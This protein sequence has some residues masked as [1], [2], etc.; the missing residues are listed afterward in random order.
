MLFVKL[1]FSVGLNEEPIMI[2]FQRNRYIFNSQCLEHWAT[3]PIFMK[4]FFFIFY[5]FFPN[6][7]IYFVLK[8]MKV[9][10]DSNFCNLFLFIHAKTLST[11]AVVSKH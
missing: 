3:D 10:D 7:W 5:L 11:N 1:D 8:V 4:V 6:A 9:I 2:I